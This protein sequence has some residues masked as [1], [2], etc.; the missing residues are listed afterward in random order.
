MLETALV[1]TIGLPGSNITSNSISSPN[2]DSWD[3]DD[4]GKFSAIKLECPDSFDTMMLSQTSTD[5][6]ELKPL[7]FDYGGGDGSLDPILSENNNCSSSKDLN[8]RSP[9]YSSDVTSTNVSPPPVV[10]HPLSIRSSSSPAGGVTTTTASSS[11]S[12]NSSSP[13][14]NNSIKL[15]LDFTAS[16]DAFDD[17]ASI[18]GIS[19]GADSTVPNL[20]SSDIGAQEWSDLDAW[21]E[22]TAQ[23]IK[24]LEG[25]GGTVSCTS[26][27]ET[28]LP[29]G[30]T[31]LRSSPL[32]QQPSFIIGPGSTLHKVL[33]IGPHH[34]GHGPN[35]MNNNTSNSSTTLLPP[36]PYSIL[37]NRLQH[38][39]GGKSASVSSD[40]ANAS[41]SFY[42]DSMPHS[43]SPIITNEDSLLRRSISLCEV[44]AKKSSSASHQASKLSSS[45]RHKSSSASSSSSS[46]S[47]ASSSPN[48][49]SMDP[50][51]KMMHHCHICNRGFLNKSNIKVHLRTH[52][53]EKPFKC[54]HC[55]KAFR[56]KAHLLKHMSIHKRISRD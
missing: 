17:L 29:G 20:D 51:K 38:G 25:G 47:S 32:T 39:A 40:N 52:T 16:Q 31:I 3:C 44:K 15:E 18:V 9:F 45:G 42:G 11:T 23:E 37:Q 55:S 19:M 46:S 36:P 28:L 5:L 27:G 33:S 56:Q 48:P 1:T 22:N 6:A 4:P 7:P 49:A 10:V 34:I 13:L 50:S 12:S 54:E 8:I 24:P 14:N 43:T 41:S 2:E 26:S 35:N 21:I 30:T 53:G